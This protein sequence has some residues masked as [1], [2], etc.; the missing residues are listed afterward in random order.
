MD[1]WTEVFWKGKW[2]RVICFDDCASALDWQQSIEYATVP[3]NI[4]EECNFFGH[5]ARVTA[6]P[7]DCPLPLT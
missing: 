2:V 1:Y 3:K 6:Y 7:T 5:P 4:R